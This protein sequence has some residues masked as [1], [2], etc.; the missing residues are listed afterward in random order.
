M[1]RALDIKSGALCLGFSP[2]I[3]VGLG[4]SDLRFWSFRLTLELGR[5]VLNAGML[6][7]YADRALIVCSPKIRSSRKREA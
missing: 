4:V 3:A 1:F 6:R 2:S 7:L 5:S